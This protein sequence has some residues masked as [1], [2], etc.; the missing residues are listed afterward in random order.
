MVA[1]KDAQVNGTMVTLVETLP[2]AQDYNYLRETAG[3]GIY[4]ERDVATYLPNTLYSVCAMDGETCVG[5]ARVV[6]DG[7]LVFYIQDVIVLPEYQRQG[8]GTEM[9]RAVMNYIHSHAVHNCVVGLMAAKGKEYFYQRFGFTCR[10]D[11][12]RGAGMTLFWKK[13]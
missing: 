9:M 12:N 10:P 8:I 11:E 7:G 3:W 6:G 1:L 4:P 2:S 5:M 13:V